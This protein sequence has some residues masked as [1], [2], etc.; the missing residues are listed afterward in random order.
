MGN[1]IGKRSSESK[2]SYRHDPSA[3]ITGRLSHGHVQSSSQHI[4]PLTLAPTCTGRS[5]AL[6]TSEPAVTVNEDEKSETDGIEY[7][8]SL[9]VTTTERQFT[10]SSSPAPLRCERVPASNTVIDF[11]ANKVET[12]ITLGTAAT[13]ETIMGALF[14]KKNKLD[15][16]DQSVPIGAR[17]EELGKRERENRC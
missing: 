17:L 16:D 15:E 11:T 6:N 7:S 1:C 9:L 8:S 2:A 14:S 5:H 12:F 10:Y 4:V 13:P 3:R